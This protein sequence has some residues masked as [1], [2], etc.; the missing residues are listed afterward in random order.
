MAELDKDYL[1]FHAKWKRR[2]GLKD[3]HIAEG[4]MR[5]DAIGAS[6]PAA[7]PDDPSMSGIHVRLDGRGLDCHVDPGAL[8]GMVAEWQEVLDD[9]G[10]AQAE[11]RKFT[12]DYVA[13]VVAL[14]KHLEPN[15]DLIL[16]AA[17]WLFA[18]SEQGMAL[19]RRPGN[20]VL[21]E[22]VFDDKTRT[23]RMRIEMLL[24]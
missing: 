3:V 13:Q 24:R 18:E 10:I 7:I 21:C 8:D 22:F 23:R 1:G 5:G 6:K 15:G 19:L 16:F 12:K 17:V 11:R 14:N 2:L 20:G 4:Y 9:N